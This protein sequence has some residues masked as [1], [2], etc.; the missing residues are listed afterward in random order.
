MVCQDFF[1]FLF[2]FIYFLMLRVVSNRSNGT[3]FSQNT[4]LSLI[5]FFFSHL[6]LYL[7]HSIFSQLSWEN[8]STCFIKRLVLTEILFLSFFLFLYSQDLVLTNILLLSFFF[9][10][11]RFSIDRHTI[12]FFLPYILNIYLEK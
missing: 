3:R 10:F 12:S 11:S 8:S 1:P 7:P 5:F 9:I 2:Y 4:L 6:F